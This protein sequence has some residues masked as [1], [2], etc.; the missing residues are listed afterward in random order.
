LEDP[1]VKGD[2]IKTELQEVPWG[3]RNGLI[4]LR[5]GTGGGQF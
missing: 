2:N 4:S 1:H 3:S 5:L